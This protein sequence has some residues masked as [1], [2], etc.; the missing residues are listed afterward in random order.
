MLARRP[1]G[2]EASSGVREG[3][4]NGKIPAEQGVAELV[5]ILWFPAPCP[6]CQASLGIKGHWSSGLRMKPMDS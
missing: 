2:W 4:A 3:T 5:T 1:W 6:R